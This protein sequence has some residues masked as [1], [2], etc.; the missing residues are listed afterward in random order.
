[1]KTR[2]LNLWISIRTSFWFIPGLMAFWAIG[3]SFIMVAIDKR[4]EIYLSRVLGFLYAGGPEGA[5][6]ILST[7]AGSMI[8]VAGV[9]F[10]ITIV[11]LTLTSSQFGPR[12]LRNFMKDTVNQVVLGTFIAT[13]IYC[14][15]VLP[16]VET[17][18]KIV[19]IPGLSVILA[20]VLALTNLGVLIYFIHHISTSIQAD[21][22]I[23][24]VYR[25]L[26]EDIQRLF[27]EEA[28]YEPEERSNDRVEPHPLETGYSLS[29]YIA[30]SQGGYLQDIDKDGLL[31]IARQNDLLIRLRYRPGEF[32]A[33]GTTLVAVQCGNR[34][35]DGLLEQ[36]SNSF[37]LGPQGRPEQDAE[38][39]VHQLVEI[40]VR[41]LS[42]GINDPFTANSCIDR[43]GSALCYLTGRA[44]PSPYHY[45]EEGK[46]RMIAKPVTFSEIINAAFDRIRQYGRSS[47]GVTIRLLETLKVIATHTRNSDQRDAVLRQAVMI[48]RASNESVPEENDKQDVQERYRALLDVLNGTD[49]FNKS[50]T[51]PT[52]K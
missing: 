34:P 50:A 46:L 42:P 38:F 24:A 28:A 21:F 49:P 35:D 44:F 4:V 45:D 12:L 1:M 8:T 40:A 26:L 14:L 47:V 43:L 51:Y 33:L 13:F 11:A 9:V 19:F 36:I 25:E 41:A 6:S 52:T 39:T 31:E 37:I 15:L 30:A 29:H 32:I 17:A 23:S 10:S 27:P 7:I 2:L 20:V 16:S 48:A 5:R 22:V 3:L 18:G